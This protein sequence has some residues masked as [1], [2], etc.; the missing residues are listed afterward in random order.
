MRRQP[1]HTCLA[2]AFNA[3]Q[4]M[5]VMAL[6]QGGAHAATA[7]DGRWHPG[8]GDPTVV[9]WITV[10]AYF[11]TCWLCLSCARH[12]RPAVFWWAVTT[13]LLALGI[14]KQLDLQTW[15]TEV[16]RDLAKQDGWY[17]QRHEI[18][19][20]F[21]GIMAAVFA[22]LAAVVAWALQGHWRAYLRVWGGMTLLLFFIVVRAASFH[23]VDQLLMSDIGGLRMNW[24]FE[25]GGLAL[26]ASGALKTRGQTRKNPRA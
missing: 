7:S 19:V 13:A 25:L 16:G 14:N 23:H 24:V 11:A 10:L 2:L 12:L 15:F 1:K 21:I 17:G 4:V 20:A 5:W 8:I 22:L 6:G 18:Q 26:I 9:G 3:L